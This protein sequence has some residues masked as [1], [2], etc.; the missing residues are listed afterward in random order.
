MLRWRVRLRFTSHNTAVT[1]TRRAASFHRMVTAVPSMQTARVRCS[2]MVPESLSSSDLKTRSKTEIESMPRFVDSESTT[3]ATKRPAL[4]HPAFRARPM[5]SRWL[6]RWR[7]SN[8]NRSATSKLTAQRHQSVT[9][10]KSLPCERSSKHKPTQNSF[11]QSVASNQTS[12]TPLRPPAL[13][14]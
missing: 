11:V 8:R 3:M 7:I 13:Q 4:A 10:S 9:Q 6:I 5:R 12:A 2:V 1:F 14:D